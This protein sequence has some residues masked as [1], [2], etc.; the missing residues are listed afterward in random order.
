MRTLLR[1]ETLARPMAFEAN[2]Q[3]FFPD[4]DTYVQVKS[5]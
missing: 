3:L 1:R 5:G 4:E 2:K